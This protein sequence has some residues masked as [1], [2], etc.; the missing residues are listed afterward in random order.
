MKRLIILF[1]TIFS[2]S[3]AKPK[4]T[5][6]GLLDFNIGLGKITYGLIDVLH[7]DYDIS[8][9]STSISSLDYDSYNIVDNFK[10]VNDCS[11]AVDFF[12]YIESIQVLEEDDS[13]TLVPVHVK[14]YAYS[15]FESTHLSKK[16][17]ERLNKYFDEV[18]VP[19]E[20]LIEVYKESGIT[21]PIRCI[22]T[23]LYL[24]IFL[25][26][27]KIT[28]NGTFTFGCVATR[29][30]RKNLKKLI[31]CFYEQFGNNQKYC[32]KIHAAD[33]FQ[34]GALEEYVSLLGATTVIVSAYPLTEKEYVDFMQSVDCYVLISKGEGFSNTPREAMALG[35]PCIITNNTAHATII[36]SG[37]VIGIDCY[38]VAADYQNLV[39]GFNGYQFDCT[40]QAVKDALS[41]MVTNY[42]HYAHQ[43][44]AMKEWV[45]QYR[46]AIVKNDFLQLL[47]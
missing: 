15:M 27:E 16:A 26:A 39:A 36:K 24:D 42:V 37:L 46:W 32:L 29:Y 11:Q 6:A 4:L 14:K 33:Y 9:Y 7:H 34:D 31:R 3:N 13:Y 35:I 18:I 21:I 12:I 23:G 2:L 25:E 47:Q 41:H 1:L 44:E 5:I 19:D 30:E 20:F 43:K 17:V 38:K 10:E 8:Y 22:P 40:D 45:K 28:S